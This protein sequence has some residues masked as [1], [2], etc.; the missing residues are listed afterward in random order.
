MAT[1][2]ALDDAVAA[3][4]LVRRVRPAARIYVAGDSAGGGLA[5]SLLL[6]LRDA[7]L[8]LPAGAV[9][10]SPWT[11]LSVSGES[12]DRHRGKDLWLTRRHLETWAQ[13]YAGVADRRSPDVSPVFGDFAGL[14]PL[15]LLVGGDELLVDDA[16][17]VRAR[18]IDSDVDARIVVSPGMQH[19]YP[20][21]L[22]WL[23]ESRDAWRRIA[24]FLDEAGPP[25]AGP[26]PA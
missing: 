22:P 12:V 13:Y 2:A 24:S 1:A 8:A 26:R 14:P 6:R 3:W 5:L 19:D 11:D 15:L 17:R 25:A 20:L 23:A 4:Q 7:G 21:T 9:L 10:L 18:A 16:V